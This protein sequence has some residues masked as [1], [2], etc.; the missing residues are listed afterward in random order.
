MKRKGLL[1][2]DRKRLYIV[3]ESLIY[4]LIIGY[5]FFMNVNFWSVMPPP[6]FLLFS[7]IFLLRGIEELK[8]DKES[9]AYYYEWFLASFIL[10]MFI[11]SFVNELLKL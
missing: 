2:E 9:M 8:E 11:I 3:L 7:A 4:I 1:D 5:I 6:M 10:I